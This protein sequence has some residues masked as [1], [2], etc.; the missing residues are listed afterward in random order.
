MKLIAVFKVIFVL[1]IQ[2]LEKRLIFFIFCDICEKT[3]ES[4]AKE[5]RNVQTSITVVENHSN[6]R[7]FLKLII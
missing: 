1:K 3:K 7:I 4:N 2:K 6:S 5:F